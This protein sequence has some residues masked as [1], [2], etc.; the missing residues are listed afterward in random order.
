MTT[1]QGDAS[2]EEEEEQEVEEEAPKVE[3]L[4]TK[5]RKMEVVTKNSEVEL[6]GIKVHAPSKLLLRIANINGFSLALGAG[7]GGP[8]CL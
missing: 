8:R 6:E 1:A 7:C 4:V 5:K 3:E 2:V